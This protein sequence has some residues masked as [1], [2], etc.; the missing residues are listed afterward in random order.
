MT[1]AEPKDE[2][3]LLLF[4]DLDGTLIVE[5]AGVGA[6]LIDLI[7]HVCSTGGAFVPASARPVPHLAATFAGRLPFSPAIGSG[8]GVIAE[9]GS[10]GEFSPIREETIDPADGPELF[11]SLEACQRNTRG[12]LFFFQGSGAG[13]E[14]VVIGSDEH[15][16]RS[17]DLQIVVGHRP[18]RRVS[19]LPKF[20]HPLLGI[21]LLA[22]SSRWEIE[23]LSTEIDLPT[24]WRAST[25]PEYRIPGRTW[26]EV[27]PRDANKA[28]A[29][30]WVIDYW[31]RKHG[32]TPKTVAVG[33]A[34]DDVGMFGV[35]DTSYCPTDA[36]EAAR[37]AASE[38]LP[39]KAGDGFAGALATVLGNKQNP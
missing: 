29:C 25:Y 37:V 30:R 38:V 14:V 4:A 34:T 16:L 21:S 36:S 12:T 6:Q 24:A 26:L 2:R 8:G 28:N 15:T 22:P 5:P 32:S 35:V 18:M 11:S 20:E 33:D 7:D 3:P 19:R 27:F 23:A 13:F 17:R 9:L 1:A 31:G 39:S 10:G